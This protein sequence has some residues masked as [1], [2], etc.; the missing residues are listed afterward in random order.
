MTSLSR[1]SEEAAFSISISS[2]VFIFSKVVFLVYYGHGFFYCFHFMSFVKDTFWEF[3]FVFCVSE[4]FP[5]FFKSIIHQENNHRKIS[6]LE[7]IEIVKAASSKTCSMM[8]SQNKMTQYINFSPNQ[9]F[10]SKINSPD[11]A[12]NNILKTYNYNNQWF[13]LQLST[14]EARKQKKLQ[15]PQGVLKMSYYRWKAYRKETQLLDGTTVE[16]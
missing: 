14:A 15:H 2:S 12:T 5:M 9:W 8:S 13:K 16:K 1:F 4:I 10:E 11:Q 7:E 3:G 6:T